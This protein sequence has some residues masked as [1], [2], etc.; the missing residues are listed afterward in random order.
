MP[1]NMRIDEDDHLQ[2]IVDDNIANKVMY[3]CLCIHMR[4]IIIVV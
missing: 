3:C 2:S 4:H 1:M